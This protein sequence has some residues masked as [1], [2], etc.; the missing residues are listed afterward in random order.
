MGVVLLVQRAKLD[1]PQAWF[2]F[3]I[4][5]G[6]LDGLGYVAFLAGSTTAAPHVAMVVASTFSMFTVFLA[7]VVLDEPISRGQWAS[8]ALIAIGTA[9]LASGL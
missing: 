8:I 1:L 2:P 4:S 9:V 6:V 7:R 3:L 5:Q